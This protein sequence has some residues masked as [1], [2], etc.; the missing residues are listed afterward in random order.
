[1]NFF[2][3]RR[4]AALHAE[5]FDLFR[6]VKGRSEFERDLLTLMDWSP[7]G[8][9]VSVD[10]AARFVL[11]GLRT[12]SQLRERFPRA[13][14]GGASGEYCRWLVDCG[15]NPEL[16]AAARANVIAAFNADFG[17][18]AIDLFLHSADLRQ[19]VPGALLPAR[20]KKF[21][22]W[23]C[24]AGRAE[25]GLSDAEVLW[26]LHQTTE[27]I[28]AMMT[29]T[30]LIT[31]S[32][33]E[34]F[35]GSL[36][37]ESEWPRLIRLLDR[38][39]DPES[40]RARLDFRR[41]ERA[42]QDSSGVNILAHFAYPSGL[43]R[44]ALE[45][46]RAFERVGRRTSC[47]NVP[48]LPEVDVDRSDSF[49]G[50]EIFSVTI[51]NVAP[52]PH[53]PQLY[54]R[55][56]WH[57]RAGVHRIAYWAWELDVIPLRWAEIA[58]GVDEIWCPTLFVAEA[59]RDHVPVPVH[60][61]LPGLEL[62]SAPPYSRSELGL[63]PDHY[64]F[65]FVFDL[66]SVMERKNPLAL[67]RAFRAA[68]PHERDV[69]LVIK[70]S[71]GFLFPG[72]VNAL[73]AAAGD[74]RI[75]IIDEL[76]PS[77]KAQG[78]IEMCDCFASLHRSEG[79]G[80]CLAEAMLR[81]KPVIGTAYSGNLA[82]MHEQNSLLVDY[83]LVPVPGG[84]PVYREGNHWA[85]PSHDHAVV[86]LRFAYEHRERAAALGAIARAELAEKFSSARA[87]ARMVSRLAQS[88]IT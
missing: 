50:R 81:G 17:K 18:N 46:K 24:K 6:P 25:H 85:D 49:L 2:P 4:S 86:Q 36:P 72:I 83:T 59:F 44:A 71:R 45:I 52:E 64:V 55:A 79:F 77:P 54:Q 40:S 7:G 32:W 53:F 34:A 47:R 75:T 20:Q 21:V 78:L 42:S 1:M 22:R 88:G 11:G 63:A 29:L 33:Q 62:E 73:R 13:I 19:R 60:Q 15:A 87:G 65:L 51:S 61:M 8:A 84:L 12:D 67:I 10:G 69:R 16:S 3:W 56:G 9:D 26:F 80:L 68:F 30:W 57:R 66:A 82:F 31:P 37:A 23:L 14:A 48:V 74:P 76:M 28:P 41:E 70:T 38:P 35:P 27:E 39:T 5:N 58:R 43:Q